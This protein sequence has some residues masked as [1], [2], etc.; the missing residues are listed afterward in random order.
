MRKG[1]R[2]RCSNLLCSAEILV[3]STTTVPGPANPRCSCGSPMK[4]P[5]S[6][7][8]LASTSLEGT[9]DDFRQSPPGAP[10]MAARE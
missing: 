2:W 8:S 3:L 4:K 6:K 7:P 1:E 5:Y 10:E 9:S